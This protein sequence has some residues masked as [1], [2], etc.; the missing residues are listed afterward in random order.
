MNTGRR[1]RH[2]WISSSKVFD[3]PSMMA[4]YGGLNRQLMGS[5]QG[6]QNGDR[7]F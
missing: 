7:E 1:S 2:A 3:R 5:K 4:A 6:K